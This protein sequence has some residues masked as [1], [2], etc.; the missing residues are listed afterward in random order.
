MAFKKMYKVPRSLFSSS[1]FRYKDKFVVTTSAFPFM[2]LMSFLSAYSSKQWQ[3]NPY[4]SSNF[5]YLA[6][7]YFLLRRPLGQQESFWVNLFLKHHCL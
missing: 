2:P 5:I 1:S 4:I 6:A 3:S 7:Y